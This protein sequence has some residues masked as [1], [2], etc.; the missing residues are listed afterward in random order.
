MQSIDKRIQMSAHDSLFLRRAHTELINKFIH[1]HS[2]IKIKGLPLILLS[3]N[4]RDNNYIYNMEQNYPSGVPGYSWAGQPPTTMNP[5]A[6]AGTSM[7]QDMAIMRQREEMVM[8]QRA[9]VSLPNRSIAQQHQAYNDP[10][11]TFGMMSGMEDGR[12]NLAR[13]SNTAGTN[14]TIAAGAAASGFALWGPAAKLSTWGATKVFG[15]AVA[16]KIIGR[17]A[18][19][20]G[21]MALLKPMYDLAD[22]AMD[23][24][25]MATDIATDVQDYSKRWTQGVGFSRHDMTR[26]GQDMMQSMTKPGQFFKADD[27]LKI[28]KMGLASG[29]LRGNDVQEYKK[30]FEQLKKD[31]KDIMMTLQTTV[32]GGMSFMSEMRGLGVRG[33]GQMRQQASSAFAM[34]GLSGIGTSNMMQ[35]GAAG[36]RNAQGTG[37]SAQGASN[38]YMSMGTQLTLGAQGN[39]QVANSI[40]GLGGLANATAVVANMQMNFA[41]SGMGLRGITAIMDHESRAVDPIQL[42]RLL[43]G[44]M[45]AG[46]ML[47]RS[48]SYGSNTLRR[49]NAQYDAADAWNQMNSKQQIGVAQVEYAMWAQSRGGVNRSTANAYA[50]QF[51]NSYEGIKLYGGMLFGNNNSLAMESAERYSAT[52]LQLSQL[53]EYKSAAGLWVNKVNNAYTTHYQSAADVVSTIASNTNKT[54]EGFKSI[55]KN[56]KTFF[57]GRDILTDES[58]MKVVEGLGRFS[59]TDSKGN[60]RAIIPRKWEKDRNDI[61]ASH[62]VGAADARKVEAA[63]GG[64][65]GDI[66][67]G[68]IR[69]AAATLINKGTFNGKDVTAFQAVGIDKLDK[70]SFMHMLASLSKMDTA[71]SKKIGNINY[72]VLDEFDSGGGHLRDMALI[73]GR[74]G[75]GKDVDATTQYETIKATK[76][77]INFDTTSKDFTKKKA[78]ELID[79]IPAAAV[80]YLKGGIGNYDKLDVID[81]FKSIQGVFSGGVLSNADPQAFYRQQ[82]EDVRQNMIANYELYKKDSGQKDLKY[83]EY[84]TGKD[85]KG[86]LIGEDDLKKIKELKE[87]AISIKDFMW[88]DQAS[89]GAGPGIV[90]NSPAPNTMNYWNCNWRVG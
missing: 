31:A 41:R 39:Q 89:G 27:Q 88:A 54:L 15:G 5:F 84:I 48:S 79:A 21:P 59:E 64:E 46:E 66:L 42:N 74:L 50:S 65:Q 71:N 86:K 76:N 82:F 72:D 52:Q 11:Q 77:I 60:Q 35:L 49:A 68:Q 29:L 62:G 40:T 16:G 90:N 9:L 6:Q 47:G 78:K 55:P 7:I 13:R 69:S 38:M 32:E 58:D 56:I 12:D 23:R 33:G 20:F 53:G 83:S 63:L 10:S 14:M 18:G 73:M 80:D 61:Y 45:S 24:N 28:N 43:T 3:H 44:K 37:W 70:K 85:Q 4:F 26:L 22:L 51:G 8:Y 87:Q 1:L 81:K 34:G 25:R 57:V 36:A 2:S 67:A 17:A 30:N 19:F 75:M